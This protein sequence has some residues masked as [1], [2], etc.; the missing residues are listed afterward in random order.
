[1][2]LFSF[3][4]FFHLVE[5]NRSISFLPVSRSSFVQGRGA[6][7]TDEHAR[8]C[9]RIENHTDGHFFLI[10][11]H[12]RVARRTSVLSFTPDKK[13]DIVQENTLQ[14]GSS[15]EQRFWFKLVSERQ[16]QV[17]A[18]KST[19]LGGKRACLYTCCPRSLVWRYYWAAI[20]WRGLSVCGVKR[21][22]RLDSTTNY[23]L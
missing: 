11:S 6:V 18:K 14:F 8:A 16:N 21:R 15:S 4:F 1:M 19:D 12:F 22:E 13:G 3:L 7:H 2:H 20:K 23:D 9:V 17:C 10:S 5:T